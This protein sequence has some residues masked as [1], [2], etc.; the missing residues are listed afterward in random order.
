MKGGKTRIYKEFL[1]I[2][3][4]DSRKK[5]KKIWVER[6]GIPCVFIVLNEGIRI[7]P[8]ATT[9]LMII[10]VVLLSQLNRDCEKR[11]DKK[12]ELSDLRESGAI[13]QDADIVMLVYRPEYYGLKAMDGEPIKNVGKLIVAKHR[14]GPVGEVKFSYNE[15]LTKIYDFTVGKIPF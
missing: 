10:T 14:D 12:P 7:V 11:T 8:F 15:S 4:Q 1:D 5:S 3:C 6:R 2:F 13:E 9:E